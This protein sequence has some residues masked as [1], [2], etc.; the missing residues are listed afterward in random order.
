RRAYAS[1]LNTWH[2][3]MPERLAER[4]PADLAFID[5]I[6]KSGAPGMLFIRHANDTQWGVPELVP[7]FH[8]RGRDVGGGGHAGVERPPPAHFAGHRESFPVTRDGRRSDLGNICV[9]SLEA[10]AVVAERAQAA[11]DAILGA[12]DL[13]LWGLDLFGGGW[14][15]CARCTSLTPSDQALRV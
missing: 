11:R 4:L 9:S 5:W 10:L 15:T 6:A 2:Y 8:R 14:C 1:D 12:T 3:T 13:H 7:E